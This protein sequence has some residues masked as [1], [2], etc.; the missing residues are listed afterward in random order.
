MANDL[1]IAKREIVAIKKGTTSKINIT[2][3][4]FLPQPTEDGNDC[5]CLARFN[6][7]NGESYNT[8]GID[9][10]QA[11]SLAIS[12]IKSRFKDLSKKY[13]FYWPKSNEP[14]ESI[15]YDFIIEKFGNLSKKDIEKHLKKSKNPPNPN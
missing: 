7:I 15:D 6:G 2:A 12:K 5:F 3:E 8:G 10:L 4:I 1:I 11:I 13:D 9:S 14:M